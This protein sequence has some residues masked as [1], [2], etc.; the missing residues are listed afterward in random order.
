[1][2]DLTSIAGLPVK[3]DPTSYVLTF[4]PDVV[5]PS[6]QPRLGSELHDVL[7][8]PEAEVFPEVYWMYRGVHRANDKDAFEKNRMRYDVTVIRPGLLGKEFVKTAG[9]YHP[10]SENSSVPY[11]EVYEVVH[12]TAHYILQKLASVSEDGQC[13]VSDVIVVEAQAG[14]KVVMLPGYGHITVNPGHV[15]LV[16][17][18][19]V[20]AKFSS[21]YEPVLR[22]KG[23]AYY[24]V[25][26]DSNAPE[27]VANPHYVN[28][29][30]IKQLKP[31]LVPEFGL[32][33]GVPLYQA[34]IETP[35]KFT[36]LESPAGLEEQFASALV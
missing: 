17:T 16:M 32:V 1:M 15:P 36:W 27:F 4:G 21:I 12:G 10:P 13:Q 29:V 19:I 25:L 33:E 9:H 7:Q 6:P 22:C 18:N 35:D 8:S 34:Y 3:L 24:E 30:P 28:P 26:G 2:F 20:S 5:W 31:A 11:P 23:G 14:D